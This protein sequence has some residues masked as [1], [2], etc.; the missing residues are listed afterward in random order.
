[1]ADLILEM[2]ETMEEMQPS[3]IDSATDKPKTIECVTWMGLQTRA[4]DTLRFS[5]GGQ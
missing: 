1:M 5:F 4:W 3:F 2:L